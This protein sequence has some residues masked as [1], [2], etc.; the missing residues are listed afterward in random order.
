MFKVS[1]LARSV[2]MFSGMASICLI[3]TAVAG[4]FQLYEQDA[5]GLGTYHAGQ[6]ATANSAATEYYN[7]AGMVRLHNSAIS[8]GGTNIALSTHFKGAASVLSKNPMKHPIDNYAAGDG[9]T[10]NFIPNFHAVYPFQYG[11]H[12]LALGFGMT[13]P[14]GLETEYHKSNLLNARGLGG[15]E[16]KLLTINLAP[17]IAIALNSQWS[18]G[19]G[20]DF[21]YG[22]ADYDG[23]L[24]EGL[25]PYFNHL[26]GTGW[27]Y[28]LGV[29]YQPSAHTR[30]GF[31][32]RSSIRLLMTGPSHAALEKSRTAKAKFPLPDDY[33]FSAYHDMNQ[34]WSVMGTV[35][36]T[37]WD[38][39]KSLTISNMAEKTLTGHDLKVN[40]DYKNSWFGSIGTKYWLT[41]R[42]AVSAGFGLD[43]TPTISKHRDIRLPDG[44]RWIVSTGLEYR[45]S[46]NFNINL[47]YAYVEMNKIRIDNSAVGAGPYVEGYSTGHA[48]VVGFQM[49]YTFA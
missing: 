35:M 12:S 47:G 46:C 49:A 31:A 7:P 27:G 13:T 32:Y 8:V 42:Y 29:L 36:F 30:Y 2:A 22:E 14:F 41:T 25:L 48:N 1:R 3:G 26:T 28:N 24:G 9:S 19:L 43:Q 4:G 33:T 21:M 44:D 15:T 17:S 34:S 45:A 6:A 5:A 18:A 39:F 37:Q 40:Y 23:D 38:L 10:S 20:V 11:G 16:T